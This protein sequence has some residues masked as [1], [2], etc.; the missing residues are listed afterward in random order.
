MAIHGGL[1]LSI[2]DG[3]WPEGYDGTNGWSIGDN[4]SH[5]YED[6][7]IQDPRD[8]LL[9]YEM[10]EKQVVP[11]FYKRNGSDRPDEWIQMVRSAMKGLTYS[12]SAHR[13]IKDYIKQIY[14][15]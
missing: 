10:L 1:N 6:P 11:L 5:E 13:M 4:A 14:S 9:L 8:A 12:F 2:P 7:S 3:W 15:V